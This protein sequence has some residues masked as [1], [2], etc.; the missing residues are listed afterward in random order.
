MAL[1]QGDSSQEKKKRLLS[2]LKYSYSLTKKPLTYIYCY[3][4][5]KCKKQALGT[6]DLLL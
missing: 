2:I 1:V 4:C 5:L 6:L 3:I